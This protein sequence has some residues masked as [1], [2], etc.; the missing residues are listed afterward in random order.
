M[1]YSWQI[2]WTVATSLLLLGGQQ[3]VLPSAE[4]LQLDLANDSVFL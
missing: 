3:A 4:A 2:L 1:R